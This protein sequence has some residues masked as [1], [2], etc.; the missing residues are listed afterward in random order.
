MSASGRAQTN[1]SPPKPEGWALR[2]IDVAQ[3]EYMRTI[4]T[5]GLAAVVALA[6][7][8]TAAAQTS[9]STAPAAKAAPPR[10]PEWETAKANQALMRVRPQ[11]VS[12]PQAEF[13][14]A[15][16]AL[17]HN[18]GVTVRGILGI[19]GKFKRAE[20]AESSG[21]SVLDANA[22]AAAALQT[23]GPAKN[24]AG[25]PIAVIFQT[26][27]RFDNYRSSE[28][29]GAARYMCAQFVLDSDWWKQTFPQKQFRETEFYTM[30]RG[31]GVI[32]R[33]GQGQGAAQALA[34][35]NNEAFDARWLKAIESCRARP[36]VR[37]ADVFK[38]EG[39]YILNMERNARQ[40]R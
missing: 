12:G 21:A 35:E 17:G 1:F 3:G 29:V 14:A 27:F 6:I 2:W 38:P 23:Y 25:E 31:L 18:G 15:E 5:T 30:M 34:R 33:L 8:S 10:D 19:D 7:A 11:W 4:L 20:V 32:A 16:K 26:T 9:D 13:P 40:K 24:E 28:G 39:D 36:A 22:L 37:F